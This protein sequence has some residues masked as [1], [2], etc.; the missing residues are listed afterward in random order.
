MIIHD[1]VIVIIV[2]TNSEVKLDNELFRREIEQHIKERRNMIEQSIDKPGI[3]AHN[4]RTNF[5]N[6]DSFAHIR[7]ILGCYNWLYVW[8]VSR[9]LTIMYVMV[10]V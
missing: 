3:K 4:N 1:C 7:M 9:S 2:I 6:D 5:G 10:Y 8:T